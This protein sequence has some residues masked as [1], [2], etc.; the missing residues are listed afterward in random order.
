V[1]KRQADAW[2]E[3]I[4]QMLI[5]IRG[6]NYSGKSTIM[7]HLA[8][9]LGRDKSVLLIDLN[10]KTDRSLRDM[11]LNS[12]KISNGVDNYVNEKL[13][14]DNLSKEEFLR[15]CQEVKKNIMIMSN[16]TIK[17]PTDK[18]IV[19][20][21][22]DA[23]KYFDYVF[24]EMQANDERFL[25]LDSSIDID[26]QTF[27]QHQNEVENLYLSFTQK[28]RF[29]IAQYDASIN[30]N[31]E[32]IIA[33]LS[34]IANNLNETLVFPVPYHSDVIN[35]MNEKL[36]FYTMDNSET[37]YV[38]AINKLCESFGYIQAPVKKGFKL[39]KTKS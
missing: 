17:T 1:I 4:L 25:S 11:L 13:I 6:Q 37:D 24:I 15:C 35:D 23:N 14:N 32:K 10:S 29:I 19:E 33:R 22:I 28:S 21:I 12:N 20:L 27:K 31:L 16:P 9:V 34:K 18:Q 36:L 2:K 26:I 30:F 7:V 8:S 5:S 38:K 39:W 3:G